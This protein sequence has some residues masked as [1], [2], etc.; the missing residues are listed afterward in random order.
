MT[1]QQRKAIYPLTMGLDSWHMKSSLS[2]GVLTMCDG[3]C[4]V[5]MPSDSEFT[6]QNDILIATALPSPSALAA[7]FDRNV[8][9]RAG[10]ILAKDCISKGS[11]LLLAPGVNIKRSVL[12]GRNF[13]Y[14]S[15]DPLLS[16]V[17]AADYINGLENSGVGACIKHY[18]ANNKEWARLLCSS[19]VSLRALNEIYLRSFAY[20]LE[21]S[22][23]SALMTSYNKVNGEYPV[24]ST[25]LMGK[26]LRNDMQYQGLVMS[27][28][29][30]VSDKGKSIKQ[31]MSLEMPIST[32]SFDYHEKLFQEYK[33]SEDDLIRNDRIMF[34]TIEKLKSKNDPFLSYDFEQAHQKAN[35]LA[36]ETICLLKNEQAYLPF[37]T[38]EKVLVIGYPAFVPQI[39]GKGS[40]AVNAYYKDP[41][42]KYLEEQKIDFAALRGYD[43]KGRVCTNLDELLFYKKQGFDQVILFLGHLASDCAEGIDAK[44][45]ELSECQQKVFAL[46]NKVFS[47]CAVSII[48]GSVLNISMVMKKATAIMLSYFAGE[49]Q[50]EAIFASVF[51]KHNPSG[52]LPETW[53]SSLESHPLYQNFLEQH[54]YYEYY[55]E[56]IFVGYRYYVEHLVED[57]LPFGYGLSYS[58]FSYSDYTVSVQT[59]QLTLFIEVKNDSMIDGADVIQIYVGKKDSNVYRP[60]YEFK[61]FEKVFLKAQERKVVTIQIPLPH[62]AVYEDASDSF[63]VES[64]R[65]QVY[66][67]KNAFEM[68]KHIDVFIEGETLQVKHE[69]TPLIRKEFPKKFTIDSPLCAAFL[70]GRHKI[71]SFFER[72]HVAHLDTVMDS[73]SWNDG[74]CIKFLELNHILTFDQLLEFVDYLNENYVDGCLDVDGI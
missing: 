8:A 52:R 43:E 47:K 11:Q 9:Y 34:E 51:G 23:P 2:D 18:C 68:V 19:E 60:L 48:A 27:D 54:T 56:D 32:R 12:C 57:I 21:K 74:R 30:A 70:I 69:P 3:P 28:W 22:T 66:L 37:T 45:I 46:V 65:Y 7:S 17:L 39:G 26:K 1:D 61:G 31:G 72:Y 49:G 15:E 71:K 40:A 25:Y 16:G 63:K 4:G 42:T 33:F 55:Y 64:G 44:T 14:W 5:R 29:G 62:L 6:H 24:E 36:R 13:E 59:N 53:I 67:G 20:T 10:I 50:N 38:K 41:F 35:E 73:F 58:T